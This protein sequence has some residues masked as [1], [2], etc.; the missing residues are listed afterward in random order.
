MP[1]ILAGV[2]FGLIAADRY[3]SEAHFVVRSATRSSVGSGFA[4]FLQMAGISRSQDDTFAVHDFI[5]SRDAVAQLMEKLPLAEIYGRPE[6]DRLSSYP[7]LFHG[8]TIEEFHKYLKSRITVIYNANTGISALQVEAFRADDAAKVADVLLGLSERI[9]NKMNVRIRE[10][11]VRF[12]SDEVRRAEERTVAAQLAITDFRNREVILD[13]GRSSVH[14]VELIARLSA[15]LSNVTALIAEV[16][17]SS[18]SSPQLPP[19]ERRAAAMRSQ[20]AIERARI[21]D[22]SDGLAQKIALFEHL[23]LEREF[24]NRSLGAAITALDGARSEARR[25]QLYLERI[26]GPSTPDDALMPRRLATVAAVFA[27][28]AV[29][30]MIAWLFMAG[31]RT[32][33]PKVTRG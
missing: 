27:I 18:P 15:E 32:H 22:A 26:A 20:I 8:A 11:S 14:V 30:I 2:Y 28:N 21:T 9:I 3:V 6:A 17:A 31:L 16:T 5:G 25:Q 24:A 1:T 23:T 4:A 33:A 29:L 12:A 19:L 10:D 7:N 13:P